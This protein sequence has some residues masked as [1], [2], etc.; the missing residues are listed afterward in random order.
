M[1][2]YIPYFLIAVEQHWDEP[3]QN[4]PCPLLY[5]FLPV[6]EEGEE[7]VMKPGQLKEL[8]GAL[9][10]I[11]VAV[12][13]QVHLPPTLNISQSPMTWSWPLICSGAQ[14]GEGVEHRPSRKVH[15]EAQPHQSSHRQL[16]TQ[17]HQL[18]PTLPHLFLLQPS[19]LTCP[20]F[21]QLLLYDYFYP[22]LSYNVTL[23][24][25]SS[26]VS[27]VL[28]HHSS[29]VTLTWSPHKHF[30]YQDNLSPASSLQ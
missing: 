26:P 1:S 14:G 13:Y 30:H 29:G 4:S 10:L 19:F 2:E 5:L 9:N 24:S 18:L 8:Q 12:G 27:S 28:P 3:D 6:Y 11:Q 15:C 20:D 22:Y 7:V 25:I 21:R 23:S 17:H 16:I